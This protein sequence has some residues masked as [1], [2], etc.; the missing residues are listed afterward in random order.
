MLDLM[1]TE[2]E[3]SRSK[4]SRDGARLTATQDS[5]SDWKEV[6]AQVNDNV[7][8]CSLT[9]RGDLPGY[10]PRARQSILQRLDFVGLQASG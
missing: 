1:Q 7:A 3:D 4:R 6:G 8:N 9:V 10:R 5:T 2:P